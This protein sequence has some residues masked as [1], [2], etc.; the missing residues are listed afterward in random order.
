MNIK[1]YKSRSYWYIN[2]VTRVHDNNKKNKKKER[3]EGKQE[4]KKYLSEVYI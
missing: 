1:V 2:P 4:I 3:R